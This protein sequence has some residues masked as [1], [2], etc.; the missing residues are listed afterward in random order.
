MKGLRKYLTP[1]AP[2]DSGAVSVLYEAGGLIIIIDA[3][4]CSGNVCGFD[5]P[6][7]EEKR[8]AIFSAGLRDMDA[9]LGRDDLLIAKIKKI[10]QEMETSFI[11]LVGTPVPAVIGTDYKGLA[12]LL[13]KE[14]NVPV[15]PIPTTGVGLY[16]VGIEKALTALVKRF[17]DTKVTQKTIGVLGFTPLDYPWPKNPAYNY[18]D[19]VEEVAS[20]GSLTKNY[21]ASM[22]GLKAAR[23]L[24]KH[25]GIPYVIGYPDDLY[26]DITGEKVLA[27]TTQAIGLDLRKKCPSLTIGSYF[28]MKKDYL[29]DH[30]VSFQEEDDLINYVHTHHFD[31]IIA[32]EAYKEMLDFSGDY[33]ALPHFALSGSRLL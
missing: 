28:M 31:T 19:T 10:M 30:M 18:Y 3:G 29:D 12:R 16:D 25:Y 7:W 15:L 11:A 13:E 21:V 17:A 5:E 26:P 24:E 33:I 8:S 4:G 14:V 32:D 20:C 22:A 6:R 23:Y 2:D 1:F 27:I 9:I